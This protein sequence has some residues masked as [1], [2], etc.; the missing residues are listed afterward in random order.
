MMLEDRDNLD[1]IA[2]SRQQT[3]V[4][5]AH[6]SL[7]A[8]VAVSLLAFAEPA[9]DW[10]VTLAFY[11]P[12]ALLFVVCRQL[13]VNGRERA[14]GWIMAI[15]YWVIVTTVLVLFGGLRNQNA[16]AYIVS[17]MVAA[18][19]LGIGP[20]T[21][22][23]GASVLASGVVVWAG[24]LNLLPTPIG[25]DS[26]VN[27]L[28]AVAVSMVISTYLLFLSLR[29]Y[30][31]ALREVQLQRAQKD[32]AV[33]SMMRSQKLE[34]VGQVAAGIAHDFN[35]LLT[36]LNIGLSS[37]DSQLETEHKG[38]ELLDD[39]RG[40]AERAGL[41]TSQLLSLSRPRSSEHIDAVCDLH[42]VIRDFIPLMSRMTGD[43]IELRF[44]SPDAALPVAFDRVAVE[45]IAMNLVM[46][47]RDAMP[48][49]GLIEIELAGLP[50]AATLTVKDHGCGMDEATRQGLFEPF[51]TTKARGTG[52]G[53][54]TVDRLLANGAGQA[55]VTS[56]VGVG[57]SIQISL[58]KAT[59][60][61]RNEDKPSAA[62]TTR[63][64]GHRI[65]LVE[66]NDLVR[67]TLAHTIG[68]A[69]HD[70]VQVGDAAEGLR[71]LEQAPFD[72]LVTDLS[73]PGMSGAELAAELVK[74][75]KD[76]PVLMISGD[77]ERP[78]VRVARSSFLTKPFEQD[79]FLAEIDA[80]LSDPA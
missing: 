13:A 53:M 54:A 69:G 48:E 47:A 14:A 25:P 41:M 55:T 80:L 22:F 62:S 33:E 59:H 34:A 18:A 7:L 51:F 63:S 12:P 50:Q 27:A 49:G 66:D 2:S 58:P 37:M 5:V 21:A 56:T 75:G 6:M 35:N 46:N 24:R 52:L 19:T 32:A 20:A 16:I 39:M 10:R 45:Q 44:S 71:A 11:T 31:I 23:T 1:L 61:H 40:A 26:D 30:D 76:L 65:L 64:T 29:S 57:T 28:V 79:R 72:L 73:L 4:A 36:V 8:I 70:L 15:V 38:R 74:R 77:Q 42:E 43:Q 60:S 78:D 68:S 67:A 3:A 9:N 17:V